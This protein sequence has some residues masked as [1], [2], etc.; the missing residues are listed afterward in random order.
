MDLI[1][2]L[3][4][5]GFT[6]HE[7]LLYLTLC[8]EGALTGYEAAKLTGISRS[9]VYLALAGLAEKGGACRIDAATIKYI[10]VPVNEM[11]QNIRRQVEE[12]LSFI[13]Q[14]IPVK[15]EPLEPYITI[16]GFTQIL[17]KMKNIITGAS[18][19]I[20]LSCSKAELSLVRS[21]IATACDRGLK[22]VLI[23]GSDCELPGA[24]V[25]HREKVPGEIRLIADSTHVLTGELSPHKDVTCL[26]S[27][28][29]NLVRLIKD[30]LT[31]EIELIAITTSPRNEEHT[32]HE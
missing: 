16:N 31:N 15:D 14:Q 28:N 29:K 6:K 13:G 8:K 2:A 24:I 19:R 22:V 23:T 20:Y 10:A 27:R 4:K 26:F 9:N 30:S 5:V 1:E 3:I 7:S 32:D 12:T 21:E 17:S 11:I 18:E 25:Y